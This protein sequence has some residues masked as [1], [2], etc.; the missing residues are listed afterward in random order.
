MMVVDMLAFPAGMV[1]GSI[2]KEGGGGAIEGGRGRGEGG[3]EGAQSGEGRRGEGEGEEGP[4]PT[5]CL[6]LT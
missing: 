2:R 4:T 3:W 5:L 1:S 6:A